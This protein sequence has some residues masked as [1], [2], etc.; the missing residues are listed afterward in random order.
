[1]AGSQS[2]FFLHFFTIVALLN[3]ILYILHNLPKEL[4][5]IKIKKGNFEKIKD[6]NLSLLQLPRNQN[7]FLVLM[8]GFWL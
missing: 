1:M 8:K 5:L 7:G 6:I 3:C 4:K 2:S